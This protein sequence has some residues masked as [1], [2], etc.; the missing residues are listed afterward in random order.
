[1]SLTVVLPV[2]FCGILLIGW[3]LISQGK[4]LFTSRTEHVAG[5]LAASLADTFVF[6]SRQKVL[7]WTTGAVVLLP[8]GVF[9]ATGNLLATAVAAPMAFMVP[10]K[11]MAWMRKRRLQMLEQQM[12]DALLM[13]AGAMRAGASFP[14]ALESVVAE[15]QPPV[16]QEFDLLLRELRLGVDLGIAMRN[17]EKRVPLA[18]FMMVT[19][20]I[21]ISR[22]VGGNLA[23]SLESVARTLREKSMMEGKIRALTAQGRM[24]G[25]VMTC[26]PLLMMLVLR[27]MEPEAM[28]PLFSE[29]VGWATLS[30]IA[31]M[32][33]LGYKS[34]T[35]I[36][37]IDV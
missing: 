1:M 32:E 30:V 31:V 37:H 28:V 12:P 4:K 33:F 6:V 10:R 8:L 3:I 19:A 7:A 25:I 34:I 11:Y 20:A 14:I 21:A 24:Q 35:K 26:L 23:E 22:E 2:I 16:S 27:H 29:P 9:V 17:M 5:E 36:T 18:D 15:A 13:M